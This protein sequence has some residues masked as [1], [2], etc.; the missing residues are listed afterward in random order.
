MKGS[1]DGEEGRLVA[2]RVI[3]EGVSKE[4]AFQLR[5]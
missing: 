3:R 5:P 4:K 1:K 2:P